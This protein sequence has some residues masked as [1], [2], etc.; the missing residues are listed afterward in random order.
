MGTSGGEISQE[1]EI[2]M[3][4]QNDPS[5]GVLIVGFGMQNIILEGTYDPNNG[6]SDVEYL[7]SGNL[8]EGLFTDA[9]DMQTNDTSA[10]GDIAMVMN[11]M[12]AQWSTVDVPESC[13]ENN[14]YVLHANEEDRSKRYPSDVSYFALVSLKPSYLIRTS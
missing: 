4:Y 9:L 1:I 11:E 8:N 12:F 14:E 10:D 6:Q 5:T 3:I 13:M 7:T 2:T